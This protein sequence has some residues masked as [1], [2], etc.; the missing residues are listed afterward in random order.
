MTIKVV[1]LS[2][3]RHCKDL[4]AQLAKAKIDHI[5]SD[6]D[7][8]QESCNSL[9]SLT[10]ST[11]YPMILIHDQDDNILEVYYLT[12]NYSEMIAGAYS[13]AGIKLIPTHSTD[14]LFRYAYNKLNFNI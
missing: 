5:F 8:D 13:K 12:D 7:K 9:E 6:C 4:K 14:S 2:G 11:Q 10:G 1:G 3:C